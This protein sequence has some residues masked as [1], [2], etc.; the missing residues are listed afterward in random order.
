[1]AEVRRSLH[2][3]GDL[4]GVLA[5][6]RRRSVVV[7]VALLLL[8]AFTEGVGLV[9]LVPLLELVGLG[10]ESSGVPG[11]AL[12]ALERV[13]IPA[14]LGVVLLLYVGVVAARA[15]VAWSADVLAARLRVATVDDLRLGAFSA[16]ARASW[17]AVLRH[18]RADLVAVLLT[19]ASRTGIAIDQLLAF[20]V[21]V[22]VALASLVVALF[23]APAVTVGA[24]VSVGLVALLLRPQLRAARVLGERLAAANRGVTAA[25]GDGLDVL[26]V[27]RAHGAEASLEHWVDRAAATARATQVGFIRRS[28]A[29]RLALEVLAAVLLAGVVWLAVEQLDVEAATLVVVAFIVGRLVM[30]VISLVRNLQHVANALPA[31]LALRDLRASCEQEAEIV[32]SGGDGR[33]LELRRGIDV[34]D[35][36]VTY[37]GRHEPALRGVRVHVPAARTT[38]LVGPSGAGKSTLGDVVL[39]LLQ[40][41]SGQVLVDGVELSPERLPAWRAE[42]AY[43]PQEVVLLPGTVR[44]NLTWLG[45]G[46]D[47]EA[48]WEAL[49]AVGAGFVRRLPDGLDTL[50][51]DRGVRLSGGERQRVVLARALLRRPRLLLLDEAT[52][53]LDAEAERAVQELLAGLRGELTLVVIAHRLSTVRDADHVVVLD[54]GAV[55]EQGTYDELVAR[56]GGR[57][58]D[59][60]AAS[61]R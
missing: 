26:K 43:V 3:I 1:M 58:A 7:L 10:G 31:F 61:A 6:G 27:A 40:P 60:V 53:A 46:A 8:L 52:S 50:V 33:A 30:R 12:D 21:G 13:G 32:P 5:N 48:C 17:P 44:E 38:A 45:D 54:G 29:T 24:A 23:L 57:F 34:E 36:V 28:A 14:R 11:A 59:L 19:D 16:L 2:G 4:V 20:T 37:P 41:S 39:G 51:G 55:V 56:R 18:R 42:V 15:A 25:L 22:V 47:D 35:V 49:G 9:L